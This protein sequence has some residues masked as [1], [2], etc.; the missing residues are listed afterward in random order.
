MR[1]LIL[2]DKTG[3]MDGKD[4]GSEF[5]WELMILTH[6]ITLKSWET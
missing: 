4:L 3:M 1:I 5:S 6:W 2:Q